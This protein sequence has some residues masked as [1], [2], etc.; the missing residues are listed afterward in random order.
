MNVLPRAGS[1]TSESTSLPSF[2]TVACTA[3]ICPTGVCGPAPPPPR[4]IRCTLIGMETGTPM[5]AASTASR[6]P[7]VEGWRLPEAG[8]GSEDVDVDVEVELITRSARPPPLP[9]PPSNAVTPVVLMPCPE[10]DVTLDGGRGIAPAVLLPL[11][12]TLDGP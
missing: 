9:P 1:P 11:V 8:R 12:A 7:E 4:C 10:T 3:V 2:R 6:A 5:V